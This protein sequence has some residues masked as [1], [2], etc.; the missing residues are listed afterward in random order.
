[1]RLLPAAGILALHLLLF[2]G[3]YLGR[4][5]FYFRDVIIN[6]V[7]YQN[8]FVQRL[9]AG[10]IPLWNDLVRG[11]MPFWGDPVQAVLYPGK[12]LLLLMAGLHPLHAYSILVALHFLFA[13]A[14]FYRLLRTLDTAPL[15]AFCG[16]TLIALSPP[17]LEQNWAFQF[18][19]AFALLGWAGSEL[20]RLLRNPRPGA[21]VRFAL[22]TALIVTTGDLQ[23]AYLTGLAALLLAAATGQNRP[24][25]IAFTVLSL[26]A[27]G[28][29]AAA[30]IMPGF[31]LSRNSFRAR[32]NTAELATEWS[33]HPARF[34]EWFAPGQFDPP[35]GIT[36]SYSR[37]ER[38][39]IEGEQKFYFP[40]GNPGLV[41]LVLLPAALSLLRRDG[42]ILPLL[43]I[44]GTGL[45]IAAGENTP[46]YELL[47]RLLP[48][49][50]QFRYPERLLVPVTIVLGIAAAFTVDRMA[51][52]SDDRRRP[53]WF[54]IPAS[55]PLVIACAGAF[56][57]GISGG[58]SGLTGVEPTGSYAQW[59][60]GCFRLAL[61]PLALATAFLWVRRRDLQPWLIGAAVTIEAISV[62]SPGIRSLPL[63]VFSRRPPLAIA[64]MAGENG[65]QVPEPRIVLNLNNAIAGSEAGYA[66]FSWDALRQ[67]LPLLYG[68]N[69]A[70]G[71][72][73]SAPA[74]RE[75][76]NRL[77]PASKL[78]RIFD[79]SRMII[80]AG[81]TPGPGWTCD[82]E[83][84]EMSAAICR[85]G[86]NLG[87]V[88]IP[89]KW[90]TVED[91]EKLRIAL[92]DPDWDPAGSEYIGRFSGPLPD[93]LPQDSGTNASAEIKTLAWTP[94]LR[95]FH[96]DRDSSGP[97]I[98]RDNYFPGWKV[99]VD[100]QPGTVTVANGF[101]LAAWTPAGDHMVE[102]R[103]EPWT[104]I[105]GICVS[106]LT[107]FA[108][109]TIWILD[110]KS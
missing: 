78:T 13:H 52:E 109:A 60:A 73:S 71:Y 90:Q 105:A 108:L 6:Y 81:M 3:F 72:N 41:I 77:I 31:E 39:P 17:A 29:L 27:A 24:R 103:Y 16:S 20:V 85:S 96:I 91:G 45:L 30:V 62:S 84:K 38:G 21:A 26:A 18:L 63:Q 86:N 99:F 49:W 82:T 59:I 65:R 98:L 40:R 53:G 48:G 35:D 33:W 67:N 34:T 56:V 69:I 47:R 15:A 79:V 89:A 1:M 8:W 55:L 92:Q 102:F 22:W 75:L 23:T 101:E 46:L 44:A 68:S 9:L 83:I 70:E 66:Q 4:E 80:P 110:K 106:V 2:G 94:E 36:L 87:A 42:R 107:V 54:R 37:L 12:L 50:N 25:R 61:V 64:L 95:R 93:K 14:G 97:L 19:A 58:W 11:G 10:E 5:T 76:A 43:A 51:G 104:V 88:R 100:G 74:D 57:P 32:E 28:G 7:P